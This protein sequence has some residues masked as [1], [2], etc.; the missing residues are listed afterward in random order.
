MGLDSSTW[1]STEHRI[2]RGAPVTISNI[3]NAA[4]Y[5]AGIVAILATLQ[6]IMV[7]LLLAAK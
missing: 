5:M 4:I 6:L 1:T 7:T 3:P 2:K